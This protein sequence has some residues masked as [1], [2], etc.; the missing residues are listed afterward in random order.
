MKLVKVDINGTRGMVLHDDKGSRVTVARIRR[1]ERCWLRYTGVHGCEATVTRWNLGTVRWQVSLWDGMRTTQ[2]PRF[3]SLRAALAV[4]RQ[5]V[6]LGGG[7]AVHLP[8][9]QDADASGGAEG[10][11]V[12]KVP[13][14]PAMPLR[15]LGDSQ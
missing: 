12:A 3:T 1:S 14:L 8:A 15:Y 9:G 5:H 13:S 6:R 7:G 10:A 2:Q 4:A 11:V